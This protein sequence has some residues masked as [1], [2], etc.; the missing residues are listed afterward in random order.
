MNQIKN[1]HYKDHREK[2]ERNFDQE[3]CTALEQK[4][5]P[6]IAELSTLHCDFK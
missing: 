3:I 2:Q 4:K 6:Q 5:Y 1:P